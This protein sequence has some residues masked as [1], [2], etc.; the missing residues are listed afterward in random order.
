MAGWSRPDRLPR[1]GKPVW[2]A[3]TMVPATS[4][5][6]VADPLSSK[7]VQP[8]NLCDVGVA[9]GRAIA[10][11]G[12]SLLDQAAPPSMNTRR[13]ASDRASSRSWS[14]GIVMPAKP[15]SR[16]P[17]GRRGSAPGRRVQ[18]GQRF[19]E[20]QERPGSVARARARA[21]RC[22]WPEEEGSP[23][24]DIETVAKTEGVRTVAGP[25]EGA[26]LADAP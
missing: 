12:V 7:E 20:R 18:R 10:S 21:T 19:V 14:P 11:C 2:L 15:R 24:A 1:T 13:S 22:A 16:T 5:L 3:T 25:R 23:G 9:G 4:A 8:D 17:A 6:V 26:G